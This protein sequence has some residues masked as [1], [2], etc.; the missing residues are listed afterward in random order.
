MGCIHPNGRVIAYLKYAPSEQGKYRRALPF[1]TIPHIKDTLAY[2]DKKYPHYIYHDEINKLNFSSVPTSKIKKHLCPE[3]KLAN[4][5]LEDA[6]DHLERKTI[7]LTTSLSEYSDI[8]LKYF[9]VTGSILI[10]IHSLKYSDIDITIY[11]LF[12]SLK[13]KDALLKLY[14]KKNSGFNKFKDERLESWIADKVKHYP[15][16]VAE[17]EKMYKR[18]WNR[19]VFKGTLFSIHPTRSDSEINER[20]SDKTVNPKG[21]IE[22]E[23]K[24]KDAAQ[25]I[26][27]PSTYKI[28]KI[29]VISGL[30]VGVEEILSYEGLY[31][32]IFDEGDQIVARGLLEKVKDKTGISYWRV[33]I[34]S[35]T[36]DGR[37]YVKFKG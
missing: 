31:S 34:G 11:G 35:L 17:A 36:A 15:L 37:D 1:Y 4:I 19:S 13:V 10:G 30:D 16:T 28:E 26:F 14:R 24:I 12:N 6:K 29:N 21:L 8:P 20:Y 22:I 33:V 25:S 27:T 18:I 9:G 5:F 3:E 2:L 32:G 23:A 7:N